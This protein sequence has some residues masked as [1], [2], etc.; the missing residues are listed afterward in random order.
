MSTHNICFLGEIKKYHLD[1]LLS[2]DTRMQLFLFLELFTL[3]CLTGETLHATLTKHFS[4]S[5]FSVAVFNFFLVRSLRHT[6]SGVDYSFCLFF[7]SIDVLVYGSKTSHICAFF[8]FF[9]FFF[10]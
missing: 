2:G 5:F 4:A 1:A 7:A 9:F 3:V 10:F 8:F 6:I